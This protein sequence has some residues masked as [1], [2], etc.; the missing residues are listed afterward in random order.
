MVGKRRNRDSAVQVAESTGE[1]VDVRISTFGYQGFT[2]H[3]VELQVAS[4]YTTASVDGVSKRR[5]KLWLPAYKTMSWKLSARKPQVN[6]ITCVTNPNQ[7]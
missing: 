2:K 3:K 5:V 1:M 6:F 7:Q 4:E